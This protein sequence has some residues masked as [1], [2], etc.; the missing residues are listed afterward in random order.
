MSD[1]VLQLAGVH[2]RRG[3]RLILAGVTLHTQR[4]ELV[5]IMGPSGSGKTTILRAVAGLEPFESGR[6][7][8]DDVTLVGGKASPSATLTRS[9]E[10]R[11]V[12]QF[13]CLLEHLSAIEHLLAPVHAQRGARRGGAAGAGAGASASSTAPSLASRTVGRRGPACNHRPR[14]RSIRRCC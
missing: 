1:V 8:V 12:F 2:L 7:S 4:G 11:M 10:S 6:R 13:H 3:V 9:G 14:W 5:A